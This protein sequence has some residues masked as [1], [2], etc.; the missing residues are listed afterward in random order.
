[1]TITLPDN[2]TTPGVVS[3]VGTVATT[4]SSGSGSG[5]R[6]CLVGSSSGSGTPTIEVEVTPTDPAATGTLDQAPVTVTITTG[7]GERR[8]VVPVDALARPSAGGYAVEVVEMRRRSTTCARC[9]WGFS[10][11]PTGWSRSPA[12]DSRLATVSWSPNYDSH[13]RDARCGDTEW[14]NGTARHAGGRNHSP[15]TRRPHDRYNPG[16]QGCTSE[17]KGP[18]TAARSSRVALSGRHKEWPGSF[19]RPKLLLPAG[20][21][22]PGPAPWS[23]SRRYQKANNL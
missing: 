19:L 6:R 23:A 16:W 21:I 9:R 11:T 20:N 12:R 15:C 22:T 17:W 14:C 8:L 10:T 1:M 18:G 4:P 5:C 2:Q 3:S 7:S 13:Q